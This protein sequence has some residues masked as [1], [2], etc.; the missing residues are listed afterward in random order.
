MLE[1][2]SALLGSHGL[3]PP[4]A[5]LPRRCTASAVPAPDSQA[6]SLQWSWQRWAQ[7]SSPIPP[8]EESPVSR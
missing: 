7:P 2:V 5:W 6:L 4:R 3:R 8:L 1:L